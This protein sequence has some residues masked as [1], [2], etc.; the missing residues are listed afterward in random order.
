MKRTIT[1]T[2][3]AAALAL[4]LGLSVSA[5]S[6]PNQDR[7][8]NGQSVTVTG[9]LQKT[10]SGG[11]FLTHAQATNGDQSATSEGESSSSRTPSQSQSTMG[12]AASAN[13]W[14]LRGD[15]SDQWK[16][17][18]GQ[19]IQVTGTPEST[20]SG[21]KL[22]TGSPDQSMSQSKG[23]IQARDFTVTGNVRVLA[24]SCQ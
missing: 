22:A 9:C 21:D 16:D 11:Y 17:H 7:S 1:A 10:Q 8:S 6:M 13:V 3:A 5:Q 12:S 24:S 19:K 20:T 15:H 18:V 23:E 14:N 4:G 2:C